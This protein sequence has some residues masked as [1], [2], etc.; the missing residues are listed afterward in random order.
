MPERRASSSKLTRR[1]LLQ[2]AT[3][4]AAAVGF[5]KG[6]LAADESPETEERV[7]TKG[8]IK[9]SICAWCYTKSMSLESLAQR[10]VAMGVKAIEL[11]EP[12]D[13]PILKKYG[14]ICPMT[15]SHGWVKGSQ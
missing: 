11:V 6:G 8:R 5:P 12:E 14:L 13:W 1:G 3:A 9:Q 7:I 15:S 4:A 10:A 2:I